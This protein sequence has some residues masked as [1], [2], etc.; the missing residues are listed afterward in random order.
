LPLLSLYFCPTCQAQVHP[1]PVMIS[2]NLE[3]GILK[4]IEMYIVS[5]RDSHKIVST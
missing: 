1:N 3:W 4:S 5:L 2:A